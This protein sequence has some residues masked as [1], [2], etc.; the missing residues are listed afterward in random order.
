MSYRVS[1]VRSMKIRNSHKLEIAKLSA[2]LHVTNS[3]KGRIKSVS[4][5]IGTICTIFSVFISFTAL[6]TD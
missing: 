1:K 4:L 6:A 2:A 3:D 5:V